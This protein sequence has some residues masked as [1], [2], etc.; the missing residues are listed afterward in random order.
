MIPSHIKLMNPLF[1]GTS[2]FLLFLLCIVAPSSKLSPDSYVLFM[3]IMLV[4]IC[5]FALYI[6]KYTSKGEL[7]SLIFILNLLMNFAV[8]YFYIS[9]WDDSLGPVAVDALSYHLD[10]IRSSNL[11]LSE[12]VNECKQTKD[13]DDCG[14]PFILY[15]IYSI[16]GSDIGI[17]I[18]LL[19]NSV[20]V[21]LMCNYTFK[22]ASYY[23]RPKLGKA[24]IAILGTMPY[25][26][27]TSANGLKENFFTLLLAGAV[28]Y[29]VVFCTTKRL[30][31][32]IKFI[33][34][35]IS[36][37]F[38]RLAVLPMIIIAFISVR[39]AKYI[40]FNTRNFIILVAIFL[41]CAYLG[42]HLLTKLIALR[43]LPDNIF[44]DM[45]ELQY[46]NSGLGALQGMIANSIFAVVGP[47]PSFVSTPDKISYIT[48]SNFTAFVSIFL[49][50]LFVYGFLKAVRRRDHVFI[51][52]TTILINCIM[53]LMMSF[54]FD[55][56]Y[57]FVI[58]PFILILIAYGIQ[59]MGEKELRIHKI[60]IIGCF[61][62]ILIFNILF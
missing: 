6:S 28:Y 8:R 35:T 55:F 31:N 15:F 21:V 51:I 60:Y 53:V 11:S 13:I 44:N 37:V 52:L 17:H 27:V 14:F 23:I 59:E 4:L 3:Q 57:R 58:F 25:T 30:G 29:A 12:F 5:L 46:A 32:F 42:S 20:A 43:G 7:L 40:K 61:L 1:L 2:Y 48:M 18:A 9:H 24:V 36:T 22:L 26:I 50:S 38:F 41:G 49:G 19:F 39:F 47:I 62:M 56:R 10:A 16:F 33:L 54:S 34:F 45:Y